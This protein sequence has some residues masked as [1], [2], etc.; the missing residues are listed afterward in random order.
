[1]NIQIIIKRQQPNNQTNDDH[2]HHFDQNH[3]DNDFDQYFFCFCFFGSLIII[4][5]IGILLFASKQN[6]K[7]VQ[8]FLF[9]SI[10]SINQSLKWFD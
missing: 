2:D 6:K 1:M 3:N 8:F 4:I 10:Q 7:K 9:A 5:S